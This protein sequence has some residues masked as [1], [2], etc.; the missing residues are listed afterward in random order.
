MT[1][2]GLLSASASSSFPVASRVSIPNYG[3]RLPDLSSLELCSK[4]NGKANVYLVDAS[5]N[6]EHVKESQFDNVEQLECYF[7][8]V[9]DTYTVRF[10]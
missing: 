1:F 6:E 4:V 9:L 3:N 2:D 5:A 8:A 10:M 7:D